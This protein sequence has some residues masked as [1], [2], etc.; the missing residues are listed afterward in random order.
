MRKTYCRICRNLAPDPGKLLSINRLIAE[1]RL[2]LEDLADSISHFVLK[3][4]K[5]VRDKKTG[6]FTYKYVKPTR[7]K[8]I[9][10]SAVEI[11]LHRDQCLRGIVAPGIEKLNVEKP[12]ETAVQRAD[13][14]YQANERV[15]HV[16][17]ESIMKRTQ[18]AGGAPPTDAE[19]AQVKQFTESMMKINNFRAKVM[20]EALPPQ[21][22][23]P[24]QGGQPGATINAQIGIMLPSTHGKSEEEVKALIE[25]GMQPG[26]GQSGQPKPMLASPA[27]QLPSSTTVVVD[28]ASVSSAIS[29][30]KKGVN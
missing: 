28:P 20:A 8:R 11:G 21:G 10:Y 14:L 25:Q 18:T 7:P 27:L 30:G 1:A 15:M 22:Q 4:K 19:L 17:V 26:A 12:N 16:I 24:G 13:R 6:Q 29:S 9:Q 2:P 5:K 23:Q 3:E